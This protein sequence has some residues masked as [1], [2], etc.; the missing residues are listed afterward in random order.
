MDSNPVTLFAALANDT[1][2]RCLVLLARR[3]E[4]CVC[5]LT[6]TLGLSQ[7]HIS[8]HLAQLR[9]AAWVQDRREGVWVYYRIAPGLP[10]WAVQVLAESA[11]GLAGQAPFAQDD[12]ALTGRPRSGPASCATRLTNSP[13]FIETP[14]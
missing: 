7:P 10:P 6:A 1:R 2:L 8:R 4:L 12:S 13:S 3:G 14:A 11:R 5:D 9:E